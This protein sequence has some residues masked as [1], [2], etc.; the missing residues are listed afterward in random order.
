MGISFPLGARL[1]PQANFTGICEMRFPQ[2]LKALVM[3]VSS[4]HRLSTS[5]TSFEACGSGITVPQQWDNY[6]LS[7]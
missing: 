5:R 1:K 2:T 4:G 7:A 3:G 6:L